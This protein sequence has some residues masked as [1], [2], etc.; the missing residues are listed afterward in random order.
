MLSQKFLPVKK[1]GTIMDYNANEIY[2]KERYFI[3][4][5]V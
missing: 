3:Y 1:T 2:C 5:L 4:S